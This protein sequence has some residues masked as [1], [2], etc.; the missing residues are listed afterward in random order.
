MCLMRVTGEGVARGR[1]GATD[2]P[3]REWRP[4]L[5]KPVLPAAA[6]AGVAGGRRR[7]HAVVCGKG[8]RDRGRAEAAGRGGPAARQGVRRGVTVWIVT[9]IGSATVRPSR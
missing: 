8:G 4:C 6:E 1:R 3:S 7:R 2:R 5:G 9:L